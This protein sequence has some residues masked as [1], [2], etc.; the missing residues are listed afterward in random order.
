M[1]L[2]AVLSKKLVSCD[3][4]FLIFMKI[5]HFIVYVSAV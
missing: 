5:T 2:F 1:T 3:V 4:I